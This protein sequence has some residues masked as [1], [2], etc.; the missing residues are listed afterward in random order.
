MIQYGNAPQQATS[1][2]LEKGET[3]K[4]RS[5]KGVLCGVSTKVVE[6]RAPNGL[7]FGP[8]SAEMGEDGA[9][10][11]NRQNTILVAIPISFSRFVQDNI[12]KH[13]SVP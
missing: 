8:S 7:L 10:A 4:R 2:V 9:S 13:T 11:R 6:L 12:E 3:R 1:S 5:T